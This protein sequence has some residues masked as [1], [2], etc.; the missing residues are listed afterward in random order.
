MDVDGS[1]NITYGSATVPVEYDEDITPGISTDRQSVPPNGQ[2]HITLTDFRL[3]LDPTEADVW[4]F[5]ASAGEQK[6][7]SI[8]TART[9]ANAWDLGAQTTEGSILTI[10]RP[11]LPS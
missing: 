8:T 1:F 2:V 5:N 6:W 9:M 3:N 11:Y 7:H 10:P 4:T